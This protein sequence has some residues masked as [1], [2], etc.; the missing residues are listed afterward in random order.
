MKTVQIVL[1][2]RLLQ[3]ADRVARVIRMNRSALVREALRRYLREMRRVELE[4]RDREG[5]LRD[6]TEPESAWWEAEATWPEK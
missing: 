3:E 2:E 1:G 6:S 4:D 5:Y